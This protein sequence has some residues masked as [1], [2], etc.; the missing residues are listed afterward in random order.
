VTAK[1]GPSAYAA[2]VLAV[3]RR[4][5]RGRVL[6]FGDV[7]DLVGHGSARGVGQVLRAHGGDVPWHRVVMA[8]GSPKPFAADEHLALLR[9][10]RTAMTADGG[11]VDMRRARWTPR[12]GG[13][14]G[15]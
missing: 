8:D 12:E 6:S 15:R 2:A 11:R 10:D 1:A 13:R 4:I 14:A 5:P 9:D 3:V 7:R